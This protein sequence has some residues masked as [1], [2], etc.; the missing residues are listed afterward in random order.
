MPC[1][2]GH[3]PLSRNQPAAVTAWSTTSGTT[4][5]YDPTAAAPASSTPSTAV[6]SAGCIPGSMMGDRPSSRARCASVIR[7]FPATVAGP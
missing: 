6:S 1:R 2:A 7:V 4:S 3:M 5:A